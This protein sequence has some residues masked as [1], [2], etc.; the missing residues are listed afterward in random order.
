MKDINPPPSSNPS[1]EVL[2]A[3]RRNGH[4]RR[5]S[6]GRAYAWIVAGWQCFMRNPPLW[7]GVS[8][9]VMLFFLLLLA[10]S[11]GALASY[12]FAPSIG[13]GMLYLAQRIDSNEGVFSD[14]F[15][16]FRRNTT[17]LIWLGV[18]LLIA[19]GLWKIWFFFMLFGGWSG[20]SAAVSTSV[21]MQAVAQ[22]G[23][24]LMISLALFILIFLPILCM[25]LWFSPALCFFDS[26]RA[27]AALRASFYACLKN[28]LPLTLYGLILLIIFSL[29]LVTA[30]IGFLVSI[31]LMMASLYH[32][33][34]DIFAHDS[35][36]ND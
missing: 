22:A 20:F 13:A 3:T 16:G 35:P 29:S 36:A 25:A 21:M 19:M 28:W 6:A 7:V 30:G 23:A 8:I 15:A 5:T 4:S 9:V 32:S 12:L 18:V 33:Y 11:L 31:P 1:S 2:I 14:L 24:L 27:N 34:L 26:M 17:S 10:I